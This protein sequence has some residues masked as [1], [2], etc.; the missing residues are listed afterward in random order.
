MSII[1]NIDGQQETYDEVRSLS[2]FPNSIL[3]ITPTSKVVF[4]MN[5]IID[6]IQLSCQG[7]DNDTIEI[8]YFTRED[9]DEQGNRVFN[10]KKLQN[11]EDGGD[12]F[13]GSDTIIINLL[14]IAGFIIKSSNTLKVHCL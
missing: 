1:V 3:D 9:K 4:K 14:K 13:L 2:I 6:R 8:Y 5:N 7:T 11:K 10:V 12:T